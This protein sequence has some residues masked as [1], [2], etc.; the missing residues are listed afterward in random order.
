MTPNRVLPALALLALGLLWGLDLGAIQP[1]RI[2]PGT[3]HGLLSA[4]GWPGAG[5]VTAVLVSIGA[6]ALAPL[7]HRYAI[8][9]VLVSLALAL[10][11]LAPELLASRH[12]P[13][14]APYARSSLGAGFWCLLFLLCLMLVEAMGRLN[15]GRWLQLALLLFVAGSWLL[16]LQRDGL[17]SLSLMREYNAR[18]DKFSQALWT[19]LALAFGAVAISAVM[20]FAL[21]L[22]MIRT[23]GWQRPI[24]GAVSFLQTIPSL[25]VFGLLIA[26][27]SALSNA[28]PFLQSLGIRGIGWAPALLALIAYSLLPMVRNTFVALT[29]V[30]ESL[31]DAGRGMGMNERQLFLRLKLPLALPVMIEGVRITAIQAVGLTAVAALIGAG[32]FGAFIFQGLGQA[33]MD[34]V[35]LGALPT[36]ALAL[37]ADALLT[38]LAN[39]LRP[40]PLAS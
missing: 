1:N 23:P 13:A 22:K 40:A 30:P 18:P 15:A 33:A 27:L 9:L 31:A 35:L 19:H 10:L 37:A 29:E 38:M 7:R 28:F 5:L 11:P 14:D 12:L 39:S 26:P 16:L 2:V 3:G 24:L 20:A 8:I 36:V 4:L 34:L 32:G 25:A 17:E 21:A 6:L